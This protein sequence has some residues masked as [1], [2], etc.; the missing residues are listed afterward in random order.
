HNPKVVGS[1]PTPATKHI[2]RCAA[3]LTDARFASKNPAQCRVFCFL[4]VFARQCLRGLHGPA[5]AVPVDQRAAH[6]TAA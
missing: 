6:A 5:H 2:W 4:R 3:Q 1:N